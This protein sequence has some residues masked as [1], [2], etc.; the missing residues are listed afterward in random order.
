VQRKRWVRRQRRGGEAEDAS[1]GQFRAPAASQPPV[2]S[3]ERDVAEAEEPGGRCREP[4]ANESCVGAGVNT[5]CVASL[6]V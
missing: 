2:V 6:K 1:R 5:E 4:S 3:V